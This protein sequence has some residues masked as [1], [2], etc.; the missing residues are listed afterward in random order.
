MV[1]NYTKKPASAQ[2]LCIR[3]MSKTSC[4]VCVR[5]GR[6]RVACPTPKRSESTVVSTATPKIYNP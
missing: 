3:K 1:I 6:P 2:Q 4:Q 5:M